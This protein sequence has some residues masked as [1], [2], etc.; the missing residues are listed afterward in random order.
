MHCST[1]MATDGGLTENQSENKIN[2]YIKK[3]NEKLLKR[4]KKTNKQKSQ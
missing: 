2:K 1:L 3:H 4:L